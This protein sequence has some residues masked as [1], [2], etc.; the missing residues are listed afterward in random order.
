M[1]KNFEVDHS[2]DKLSQKF[3]LSH[4]H[5]LQLPEW[6]ERL[7]TAITCF[8]IMIA[9]YIAH[10]CFSSITFYVFGGSHY[11]WINDIIV[12]IIITVCCRCVFGF[13]FGINITLKKF[14][15]IE[16]I[17]VVITLNRIRLRTSCHNIIDRVPKHKR[18]VSFSQFQRYCKKKILYYHKL[19]LKLFAVKMICDCCAKKLDL[20]YITNRIKYYYYY[21]RFS[22]F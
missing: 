7:G 9:G 15:E 22:I 13:H 2:L 11:F 5:S 3:E 1:S 12:I 10:L 8:L 20:K 17:I 4:K 16:G 19:D 14:L 18:M 6:M 21:L